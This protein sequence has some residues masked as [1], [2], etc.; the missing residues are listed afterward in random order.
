M[1][2]AMACRAATK[3][4][5]APPPQRSTISWPESAER[6]WSGRPVRCRREH[7]LTAS[8]L[9][10][11][12]VARPT[13]LVGIALRA[14]SLALFLAIWELAAHWAGARTLPTIEAVAAAFVDE[15]ASGE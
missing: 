10:R 7:S 11:T 2:I 13:R 5:C 1:P 3:R 15:L 12:S 6:R 14:A 9:D 8:D 4:Q